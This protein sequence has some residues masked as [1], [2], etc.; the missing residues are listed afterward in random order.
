MSGALEGVRVLDF[1][2]YVAGPLAANLLSDQG[3]EVIHVDPLGGPRWMTPADAFLNRGKRRI[4][5]D[6]KD[7]HDLATAQDLVDHSDVLVE[8]FRPGVMDRLGL[9]SIEMRR[10]N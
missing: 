7:A 1:G 3:A 6:L 2:H 9:S 5:L 10:R 8:N 4:A